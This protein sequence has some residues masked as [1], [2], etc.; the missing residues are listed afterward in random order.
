MAEVPDQKEALCKS[1]CSV[2]KNQYHKVSQHPIL[3]K[4]YCQSKQ[5]SKYILEISKA[6]LVLCKNQEYIR[7][8]VELKN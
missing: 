1:T 2:K 7:A 4:K 5:F 3:M 6:Y 8:Y